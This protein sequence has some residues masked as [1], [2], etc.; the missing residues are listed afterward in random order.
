MVFD[1]NMGLHLAP[2]F[3]IRER[4]ERMWQFQKDVKGNRRRDLVPFFVAHS[5]FLI[6]QLTLL[7]T[8]DTI[9]LKIG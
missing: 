8:G 6:Y 1:W 7:S 2:G 5:S 3:P 9:W 4:N